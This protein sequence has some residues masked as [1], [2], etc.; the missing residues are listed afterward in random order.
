MVGFGDL[1][2]VIGIVV[3]E[4][5]LVDLFGHERG[6]L[7]PSGLGGDDF[8][9][10]V[11]LVCLT[12]ARG[13][14]VADLTLKILDKVLVAL[15]GDNGQ[16]VY[17]V[18]GCRIVHPVPVLVDADPHPPTHLLAAGDGVVAMF[19]HA[20]DEDVGVVPTLPQGGVGEDKPDRFLQGEEPLLVK[21][22]ATPPWPSGPR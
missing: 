12:G 4:Q 7:H 16:D 1:V 19:E 3:L 14:G 15:V 20:H 5:I 6:N 8:S 18:N 2:R 10:E 13:E 11:G 22:S 9:G 21:C 17:I